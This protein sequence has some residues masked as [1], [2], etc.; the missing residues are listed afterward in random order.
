MKKLQQDNIKDVGGFVGGHLKA[1][2]RKK[3]NVLSRSLLTLD[4]DYGTPD[5]WDQITLFFDFKCLVYSTHRHTPVS[6]THL[7]KVVEGRSNRKYKDEDKI[8]EVAKA[9]GY[10]DIY[11]TSLITLTEMEKL[12]GK[13]KFKDILGDFIIKPPG[14]PTL[15]PLSDKRQAFNVS[16]AKTEFNKIMEV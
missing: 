5:I 8:A 3:G 16:S 10:K 15:V 2:R 14:K 13:Q 7:F 1:G 11:R 9:N 12:M 4:M 6:Y